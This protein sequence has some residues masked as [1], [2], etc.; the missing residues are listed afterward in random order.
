MKLIEVGYLALTLLG[1][2][3][4]AQTNSNYTYLALGDSIPFGMNDALVPPYSY[5]VPTASEFIGY[6]ETVAA[7]EFPFS[8]NNLVNAA[9]P[10][11][12]SGSFLST[13][14]PD[15]G[16]NSPHVV[17]PPAGSNLSPV[18]IP[19]AKGLLPSILHTAYTG[20]QMSFATTQLQK[21]KNIKLVTLQIGA[22]DGLLLL[23]QCLGVL[24]CVENG[25]QTTVLPALATNLGTILA[26]IRAEYQGTLVL[27]T[28]YSPESALDSLVQALNS[29]ITQVA[30][31]FAQETHTPP[32]LIAN[33]YAA[34]QL[35]SALFNE[36]A[37]AA[38]LL[39]KLPASLYNTSPCDIHPS[40]L[41]RDLLAATVELTILTRQ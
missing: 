12:T 39:I 8:P 15:N 22:N 11:E 34:F 10:G 9:C 18:V 31:Q 5:S 25:L 37:C 4:F 28:Y 6:P 30:A 20:A 41:G 32:I 19:P 13:S 33:G 38:G 36:N 1:A 17:Y 2:P 27:V 23:D 26:G 7:T 3:V 24:S 29:T 14:V 16:C 35:A 21:N 40:P